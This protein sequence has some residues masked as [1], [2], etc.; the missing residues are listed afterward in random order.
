MFCHTPS[1][2]NNLANHFPSKALFLTYRSWT[3]SP[4]WSFGRQ[5]T[6]HLVNRYFFFSL[7]HCQKNLDRK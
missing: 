5:T 1:W 7:S 4:P 6:L 3:P 2:I